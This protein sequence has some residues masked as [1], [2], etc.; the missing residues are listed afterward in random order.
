MIE[1]YGIYDG[2]DIS[3]S[4]DNE[5]VYWKNK[6]FSGLSPEL[7]LMTDRP[8][9]DKTNKEYSIYNFELPVSLNQKLKEHSN[10]NNISTYAVLMTIFKVL[11]YRYSGEEKI[12]V[13]TQVFNED[14]S[15]EALRFDNNTLLLRTQLKENL[16]FNDSLQLVNKEI[17]ESY[18][19]NSIPAIKVFREINDKSEQNINGFFNVMMSCFE[20]GE[21]RTEEDIKSIIETILEDSEYFGV[22]LNLLII[23]AHDAIKG[24]LVYNSYL[25]KEETIDRMVSHFINLI[26][27]ALKNNN[28]PISKLPL[29]TAEERNKLLYKWNETDNDY[30]DDFNV[31]NLFEEQVKKYPNNIA[32][33][34]G[35]V[36][37]TYKEL[38]KRTNKIANY[39]K[40]LNIKPEQLIAV[41]LNR[42]PEMIATFL[43]ILK[44]GAAYIPIDLA[45][46]KE[47]IRY[48]LEDSGTNHVITTE[49]IALELPNI[50]AEFICLDLERDTIEKQPEKCT[51][52]SNISNL[53][54]VMYT[55]GS[56]GKPKGVEIIQKG[57]IRL[58]NNNSEYASLGPKEVILNRA[59]IAFDVSVFEIYGSILNGGTLVI[60]NSSKPTFEEIAKTI[61]EKG[62]TILRV[63]PD[64]LNILIEDYTEYL[65]SLRQVFSGGEVLPIL[66]AQKF[67]KKLKNCKLINAYG[68]TENTVNTTSYHVKEV[69]LDETSIPIGRPISNDCVYILDKYLQPVP[70]GVIGELFLSGEG[71]ARGYLNRDQLT[72]E[73]FFQDPFH[74][75]KN[76]MMYKSGDLARYRADGNIEFIGRADNQVKIRGIRIELGEVETVIGTFPGIR[77]SISSVIKGLN[78][79]NELVSYVV[80]NKGISFEQQELRN[81]IRE[82]LPDHMIPTFIMVIKE[83]PLTPVGKVDR[84]SLP[85]PI[86]NVKKD[87][88]VLPSNSTEE[89]LV[90]LWEDLLDVK[91]IGVEDNYFELGGNSLIAMKMF[92]EINKIFKKDLPVSTIFQNAT[93]SKIATLIMSDVQSLRKPSP[94]VEIQPKGTKTPIFCI[95]G[96]GGEVLIYRDLAIELGNDQPL[97]GFRYTEN[98]DCADVS[99]PLLAEKYIK[100]LKTRQQTGPYAL[101]GFCLG[102]VIAYEMAQ[103][104]LQDG[105]DVSLLTIINFGNPKRQRVKVQE[106][107]LYK[108]IILNNMRI[109]SKKPLNQQISFLLEKTRNALKLVKHRV[110]PDS[111]NIRYLIKKA[112][113][114]YKPNPY[115]GKILL[116]RAENKIELE[117]NLGWQTRDKGVIHEY[118]I[119][120]DHENLIKRAN[121][122]YVA[123]YI[124]EHLEWPKDMNRLI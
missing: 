112:I 33:S 57:I 92:S 27:G 56:T 2:R 60:M 71:I 85:S 108:E 93:I 52:I 73:K 114:V 84:K 77:Q 78:G 116:I 3:A 22:E 96:G 6:F 117:K 13:G 110:E 65:S 30:S 103:R 102:G 67:L 37:V 86:I 45:Y 36:E 107:I 9:K 21:N 119:S 98:E 64:M 39:L 91:P 106:E 8:R 59:S 81:Y 79:S 54:Y 19:H 15:I 50:N 76:R 75:N 87:E 20:I 23:D 121:V 1:M 44:V 94:L 40:K 17:L 69:S 120:S 101:L 66:V 24:S 7:N 80:M 90:L 4:I 28:T 48:M 51:D 113:S 34:Y 32:I 46:P 115:P 35:K 11:L 97:F 124:K 42:S 63:G 49:E 41:C 5:L 55:S 105:D 109:L 72:K 99:V 62:V 95:H 31:I 83:V 29:L 118:I 53:A 111:P 68:P 10:T 43:A 18:K 70:V 88:R 58:V 14:N 47:R 38:D 12:F 25:Y 89:K 104:L 123:S 82:K 74:R 26:D 122:S 100:E 61:N 16:T